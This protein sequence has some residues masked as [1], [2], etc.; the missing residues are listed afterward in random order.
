MILF[1][2]GALPLHYILGMYKRKNTKVK[3]RE[4]AK[5]NEEVVT[6]GDACT[7]MFS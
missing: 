7:W 6:P 1:T 4:E 2:E 5:E 3:E